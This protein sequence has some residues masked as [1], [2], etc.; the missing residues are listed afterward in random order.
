MYLVSAAWLPLALH[1]GRRAVGPAPKSWDGVWA[2]L[3]LA[4]MILGGD[5]QTAYHVA[6]ILLAVACGQAA[7]ALRRPAPPSRAR[8][9]ELRGRV[10]RSLGALVGWSWLMLL[11]VGLAAPQVWL[12]AQWSSTSTRAWAEAPRNVW[13]QVTWQRFAREVAGPANSPPAPALLSPD[14]PP[15]P[16]HD[17]TMYRFHY[18]LW[19]LAELW[20][21]NVSGRPYPEYRRWTKPALGEQR[22]W[23]GSTYIGTVP[24]LLVLLALAGARRDRRPWLLAS[25]AAV[26]LLAAAGD[27]GLG[28][29]LN[30][31]F[32]T[33]FASEV[34][35]VYWWLVQVLPGYAMFRYPA[36]WLVIF[37]WAL[38]GLAASGWDATWG[39][40]AEPRGYEWIRAA[41]LPGRLLAGSIALTVLSLCAALI[42]RTW[43]WDLETRAGP[44]AAFGPLQGT[45]AW[46]DVVTS[47]V[48]H[49]L[50]AGAVCGLLAR[51]H[52]LS[53]RLFQA[54]LLGLTV[55]DLW[56]A[57]AGQ[58]NTVPVRQ[59]TS[60]S[61][62]AAAIADD[63]PT[64]AE[65]DR[66]PVLVYRDDRRPWRPDSWQRNSSSARLAELVEWDV[67]TLHPK[68]HLLQ[69][70]PALA[71]L[72]S[73]GPAISAPLASLLRVAREAP[74]ARHA[75]PSPQVLAALGVQYL[76]EPP[77]RVAG[78]GVRPVPLPR[79]VA[80][81]ALWRLE[82]SLPRVA[83][84][85]SWTTVPSI[86]MGPPQ[87]LDAQ[88]RAQ[89]FVQ[90]E[91]RDFQHWAL[92]EA[93]QP[94]P[95]PPTGSEPREVHCTWRRTRD[96][97]LQVELAADTAGF[98]IVR[99]LF[100]PGWRASLT[101]AGD[102]P[103][104]VAVFRANR[105]MRGVY[106]PAGRHQIEF[107]YQPA[108]LSWSYLAWG[109]SW[110]CAA[111]VLARGGWSAG[112]RRA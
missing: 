42:L 89:L 104:S 73:S 26:S 36:K 97:R 35:G 32:G 8:Q 12:S 101:T 53:A 75:Q 64:S 23:F 40:K 1:F 43:W 15:V 37:Q 25:C 39:E 65:G 111:C 103:R 21:P 46:R 17:A 91:L 83:V 92:I 62:V 24:L 72:E 93:D 34:G 48:Q 18:P 67:D 79:E 85:H 109:I 96:G 9:G 60:R 99:E 76:L 29:V 100:D 86:P 13:E 102:Q 45:L 2:A 66:E 41:R 52:R 7:F 4:L 16:P 71:L 77:E 57:H 22:V 88:T 68:F 69:R 14:G 5:P 110:A 51:R 6:L 87:W 58:V 3:A 31:L 63:R 82:H 50:V 112:W 98:L 33:A 49:L 19:R 10:R 61:T 78:R 54:T 107:H 105:V 70:E 11:A 44:D 106:F 84:V 90:G 108:H 56:L 27:L 94:V 38:A 55:V 28:R 20:W 81:A 59:F 30:R 95:P 47:L 80:G 74:D